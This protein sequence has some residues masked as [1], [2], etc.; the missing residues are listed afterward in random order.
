M[1]EASLGILYAL[2]SLWICSA[3]LQVGSCFK[4]SIEL[5]TDKYIRTCKGEVIFPDEHND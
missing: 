5:Y 2:F 4:S 1:F 3:S